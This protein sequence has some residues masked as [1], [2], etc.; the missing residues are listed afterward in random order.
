MNREEA[1][2][3]P[4]GARTTARAV[5]HPHLSGSASG[6]Q[7]GGPPAVGVTVAADVG[8]AGAWTWVAATPGRNWQGQVTA[9]SVTEAD[10][11]I[12]AQLAQVLPSELA[13]FSFRPFRQR[14]RTR[15]ASTRP[16]EV[17]SPWHY[18]PVCSELLNARSASDATAKTRA[19]ALLHHAEAGLPATAIHP[20]TRSIPVPAG[21]GFSPWTVATDGSLRGGRAAWAFVTGSGWADSDVLHEGASSSSAEFTAYCHALAIY[22][23]GTE[24]TLVTDSVSTGMLLQEITE[25]GRP[26]E[27]G[28]RLQQPGRAAADITQ[29]VFDRTMVHARRLRLTVQWSRRNTHPLQAAAHQICSQV[30]PQPSL[31][32]PPA[33]G[34]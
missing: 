6:G 3:Y 16:W 19:D 17:L 8:K 33:T 23:S 22:P 28:A 30:A 26:G 25:A 11:L 1:H 4:P 12:A 9:A 29:S 34:A 24:V 2:P 18:M 31:P 5:G 20:G 13:A 27:L 14:R 21:E 15:K 10:H 7:P 32:A